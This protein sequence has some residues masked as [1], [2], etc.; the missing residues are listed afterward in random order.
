MYYTSTLPFI[1]LSSSML[2]FV[3]DGF[4]NVACPTSFPALPKFNPTFVWIYHRYNQDLYR[5]FEIRV[6]QTF[7]SNG[8]KLGSS[9]WSKL[10]LYAPGL[11][12]FSTSKFIMLSTD[13]SKSKWALIGQIWK[14]RKL[15]LGRGSSSVFSGLLS[16]SVPLGLKKLFRKFIY[17]VVT[18]WLSFV[19]SVQ[20]ASRQ[21]ATIYNPRSYN[22]DFKLFLYLNKDVLKWKWL[23]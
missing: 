18:N 4:A 9:N 14:L 3:V 17:R 13:L 16:S 6:T 12:T 1:T 7:V 8:L 5:G 10:K 22:R 11:K 23:S 2:P 15:S 20:S 21:F 19:R